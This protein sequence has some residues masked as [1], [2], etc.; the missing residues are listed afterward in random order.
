MR[1][2][3]TVL[4]WG[5]GHASRSCDIIHRLI[6]EGNDVI[7]AGAGRSLALLKGDFPHLP[8]ISIDSFTPWFLRHWPQWLS[9][10]IQVPNMIWH[11]WHEHY[12]IKRLA[13]QYNIDLI[14]SDNRYGAHCHN[15]KSILITHQTSP[16]VSSWAPRWLNSL[17]ARCLARWINRFDEVWIPDIAPYPDGLAGELT[18]SRFITCPIKYIG[19]LSRLSY[20]SGDALD[21]P[22]H[23]DNLAI[24]S[25]PEPFRSTFEKEIIAKMKKNNGI[26]VIIRGITDHDDRTEVL[27][28]TEQCRIL[29]YNH[30]NTQTMKELISNSDSIYCHS[31]YSTLMDLWLLN[32]RAYL[33]STPGQAEQEYLEKR[34]K[35]YGFNFF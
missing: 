33:R 34:M 6:A 32:K 15:R 22:Q 28:N 16:I 9:I 14:I 25:G 35:Q 8:C 26:N 27:Q 30:C 23:I 4:D 24:L 17:F 21:I 7:I 20:P 1:V 11:T 18:N 12:V 19:V 2:L 5:L 3:V 31:G 13:D 29:S 10:S